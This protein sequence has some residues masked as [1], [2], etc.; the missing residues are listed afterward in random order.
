PVT[1]DHATAWQLKSD[2]NPLFWAQS[3]LVLYQ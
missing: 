3:Y 2:H 1:R